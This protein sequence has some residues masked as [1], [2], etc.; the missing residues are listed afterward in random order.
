TGG[1]KI[2]FS[3]V[4]SDMMGLSWADTSGNTFSGDSII[5]NLVPGVYTCS[6][7][8]LNFCNDTT[9]QMTITSLTATPSHVDP[10]CYNDS[11]G[12]A[13]VTLNSDT[14]SFNYLWNTIPVQTTATA[15]GLSAGTYTCTASDVEGCII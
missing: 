11:N 15:M 5:N 7:F 3:G 12:T 9:L 6:I 14:I 10:K 13:T 2:H 1:V 4:A 8:D